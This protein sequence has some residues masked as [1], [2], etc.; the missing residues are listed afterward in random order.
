MYAVKVTEK[1]KSGSKVRVLALV[2]VALGVVGAA[3]VLG[4]QAWIPKYV[5]Q[6]VQKAAAERG[7]TL[8]NCELTYERSG[9]SVTKV[10]LDHCHIETAA[11][12]RASGTIQHLAVDLTENRPTR[13]F[14]SGADVTVVG[15]PDWE[16]WKG[17][18]GED[19]SLAVTGQGN[20][21]AWVTDPGSPPAVAVTDLQRLSSTEDW[22]G[23]LVL[24]DMLDGHIRIG[25]QARLEL[26]VRNLPGNSLIAEIDPAKSLGRVQLELAEVPFMLF[27]GILFENVPGEL[28]TT[29]I[30]GRLALDV[31]YALNTA[32]PKGQFD[33]TLKGLNFPVPREVAGLIHDTSPRMSGTLTSNR[34]YTKFAANK[35]KFETG[36]LKMT[37]KATVEREGLASH[38]LATM[39]GP[40][41]CD[42]IVAAAARVHLSGTTIGDEL[43]RAAATISRKALK[44]SVNI[45]VALDAQSSDLASAKLV[46]SVGIGCGLQPLPIPS[47]KDLP[48]ILLKDLPQLKDLPIGGI[49]LGTDGKKPGVTL[50]KLE[51]PKLEVPTLRLPGSKRNVAQDF[52][53]EPAR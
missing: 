18:F 50:P 46:K 19:T 22:T 1:T 38:W 43:S 13:A 25:E 9:F 7:V 35:V 17:Q 12:L 53:D 31:P 26:R 8:S 20:R 3:A 15:F 28:A 6:Q 39:Q 37:G 2:L 40:L 48:E 23:T 29:T 4:V 33:L 24:A 14:I 52:A 32:E 42:A 51:L 47:L 10:T 44:G 41:P 27:S 36:A 34:A 30:S 49:E 5:M 45:M 21:V 16:R 11:P